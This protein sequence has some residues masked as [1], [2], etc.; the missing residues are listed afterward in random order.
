MTTEDFESRI[1]KYQTIIEDLYCELCEQ[2]QKN[3][4]LT[5]EI[6]RLKKCIERKNEEYDD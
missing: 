4:K 1:E 6:R 2:K 3:E 5:A